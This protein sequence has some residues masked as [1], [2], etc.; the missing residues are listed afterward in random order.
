MRHIANSTGTLVS[1]WVVVALAT[2]ACAPDGILGSEGEIADTPDGGDPGFDGPKPTQPCDMTGLWVAQQL[3]VSRATIGGDQIATNYYYYQIKQDGDRFTVEKQLNCGFIVKSPFVTVT[4]SDN[5]LEALAPQEFAGLGRQGTFKATADG[6]SCELTFD[7]IYDLRGANKA[8]FLTDAWKVGDP[9]KALSALPPL[10]TA[11]PGM[12][13]WDKDGKEGFTVN[14]SYGNR[15][16]TQR[17]WN[18]HSGTVP[19]FATEFGGQGVIVVK[20]DAQEVISV[21]DTPDG[22]LRTPSSPSGDGWAMYGRAD[23]RLEV[24]ET[25]DRPVLKTCKNV[26]ALARKIWPER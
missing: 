9:P 22:P 16:S 10:P 7:R 8:Q 19:T 24:V 6:K 15:A 3:T 4:L 5:T 12:E 1:T 25:G 26:Q 23:G 20:W 2:A 17:D 21:K 11:A 14:T 18:E 13:D